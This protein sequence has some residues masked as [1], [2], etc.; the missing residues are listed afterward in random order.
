MNSESQ[1]EAIVDTHYKPLFRFALSLTR[2]E[3]DAWDLTQQ[4]FRVWAK[5]G[6]QLSDISKVKAWLFTTLHREFLQ[7]RR[8]QM[9]FSHCQLEAADQLQ[10]LSTESAYRTDGCE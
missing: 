5:K 9:R 10:F 8:R 7:A 6:D 1:F 3:S 2:A 4:T